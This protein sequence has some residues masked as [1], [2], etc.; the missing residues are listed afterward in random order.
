MF[1]SAKT[2]LT[3]G[4]LIAG[5][6]V[7]AAGFAVLKPTVAES[8]P[9]ANVSSIASRA[10]IAFIDV[11]HGIADVP[12][13]LDPDHLRYGVSTLAKLFAVPTIVITIQPP[14]EPDPQVFS[15]ITDVLGTRKLIRH[16]PNSCNDA[17]IRAA[18]DAIS[19]KTLIISGVYTEIAVQ[20]PALAYAA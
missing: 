17:N 15:D 7:A 19:R 9:A 14:G 18:I 5:S 10:V 8:A 2:E 6:A 16:M 13:T 12:L 4:H 11:Q 3:R 20:T 1:E